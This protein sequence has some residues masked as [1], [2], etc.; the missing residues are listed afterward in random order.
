[1]TPAEQKEYVLK[2]IHLI[3]N[4][5]MSN[6]LFKIK[7]EQYAKYLIDKYGFELVS[8]LSLLSD[9]NKYFWQFKYVNKL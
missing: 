3:D 2:R 9:F 8:N 1:M 7:S 4:I 5:Q 6:E